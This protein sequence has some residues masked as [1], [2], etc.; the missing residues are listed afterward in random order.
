[1]NV[2]DVLSRFDELVHNGISSQI[3]I[4]WL[5]TIE[6]RVYREVILTHEDS[7]AALDGHVEDGELV[8]ELD[9]EML[10]PDYYAEVY[11]YF[12]EA[13]VAQTNNETGR[14]NNAMMAYNAAWSDFWN[15]YNK[16]HLPLQE[17]DHLKVI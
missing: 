13:M 3:K 4:G 16:R 1:M 10:I 9:S 6:E 7:E 15:F 14:Y 17:A 12:L 8:F 5:K 11:R 2:S